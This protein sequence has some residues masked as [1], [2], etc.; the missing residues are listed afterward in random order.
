[1]IRFTEAAAPPLVTKPTATVDRSAKAD[2]ARAAV[3]ETEIR[4]KRGRPAKPETEKPWVAAK[5][6]RAAWYR[7]QKAKS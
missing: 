3:T 4:R 1:M 2:A 6:S 7:Q 5:L